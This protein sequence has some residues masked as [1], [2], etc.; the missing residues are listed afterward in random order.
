M[1]FVSLSKE[2]AKA[3]LKELVEQFES[4]LSSYEQSGYKEGRKDR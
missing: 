3:G 1:S 2:D 4:N